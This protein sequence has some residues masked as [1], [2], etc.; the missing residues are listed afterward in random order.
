MSASDH[1]PND[2]QQDASA[3]WLFTLLCW[4][5]GA[6]YFLTGI[7]P[8]ISIRSFIW[9]T[10]EKTDHL[11]TRLEEDHWLVMT[12]AVLVLGVGLTLLLAAWRKTTVIE[13]AVLAMSSNVGLTAID[14]IYTA[15]GVILPIYLVDAALQVPLFIAW[16]FALSSTWKG[17]ERAK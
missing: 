14:C 17:R 12:V 3:N 13:L 8:L 16:I 9:V 2:P 11:P 10:G 15:R 6:Y 7:W 5:Q 4:I 1:N